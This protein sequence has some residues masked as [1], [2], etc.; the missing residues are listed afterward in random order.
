MKKIFLTLT[1]LLSIP[2]FAE[3]VTVQEAVEMAIK[4][5]KDIK[6]SMLEYEQSQL[7]VNK[8]WKDAYF[9][10]NYT[11]EANYF[12]K[13]IN[14]FG[15]SYDQMYSQNITLTQPL[16]TGGGIRAGIKIGENYE[17]FYQ[18]S[19]DKTRKDVILSTIDAY[20]DL[21]NA[22][23][24]LEVLKLS[25]ET[26]NKN[27][28]IQKAKYELRMVTKPDYLESE[29]SVAEID[30]T[31]TD[32]VLQID[33]AREVLANFIGVKNANS[34]EIVPFTIGERFSQKVSLENDLSRL[35]VENTEYKMAVKQK[36][37]AKGNIDYQ[38][39]SLMPKVNGFV[40]YG[41]SSQTEFDALL[42]E[43]NYNGTI[44][45]N[46]SWKLFDWGQTKDDIK[47]SDKQYQIYQLKE[48]DTLDSLRLGLRQVYYQL[49][50]L[51]KSLD[52]KKIAMD[53]ASEVYKLEQERYSYQL[54]T[55]RDLL[56]AETQLRQSK[57]DYISTKLNYYYL[58][59]KY[60]AYLD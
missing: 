43:K 31:V 39:S 35:L 48:E 26:L 49:V 46:V 42:K 58:V 59:S 2:V 34:L 22:Q 45:L 52:A 47:K 15:S 60:G 50:S 56:S 53:R 54:I 9:K 19:L 12:F 28:E 7:D 30:A 13:T 32:A 11:A 17:T 40:N 3:K 41:T 4:N 6:I 33:L 44:G 10:I 51:E 36:E 1:I 18:L 20:I 38:K 23:N 14:S 5:N 16:Y 55:L 29:R 21:L 57:I 25:K 37:I 27:L 8:A 24:N